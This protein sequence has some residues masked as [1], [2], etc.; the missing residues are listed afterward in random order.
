MDKKA[1][2]ELRAQAQGLIG[3]LCFGIGWLVGN[4]VNG[5]LIEKYTGADEIVNWNPIWAI[6]T[7]CSVVLLVAFVL[8]FK[9]DTKEVAVAAV[10]APAP[11]MPAAVEPEGSTEA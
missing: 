3:L 2:P 1:P 6:T 11:E 4:F 5:M 7:I 10:E 9:D 8:L